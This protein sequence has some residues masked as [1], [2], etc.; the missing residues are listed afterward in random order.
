MSHYAALFSIVFMIGF[1]YLF[2][3][4]HRYHRLIRFFTSAALMSPGE[5]DLIRRI[6]LAGEEG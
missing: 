3:Y 4:Q 1:V 2:D 5:V 6:Q